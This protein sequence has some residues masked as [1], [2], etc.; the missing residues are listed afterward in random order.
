LGQAALCY[1]RGRSWQGI[2]EES[3]ESVFGFSPKISTDVENIVEN[4]PLSWFPQK[5][6][7]FPLVPA[8]QGAEIRGF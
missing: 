8:C 5:R 2:L 6:A 3:G 4:V 7:Y 1:I